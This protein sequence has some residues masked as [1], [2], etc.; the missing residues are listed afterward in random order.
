MFSKRHHRPLTAVAASLFVLVATSCS[1]EDPATTP[2]VGTDA[3][4][5]RSAVP[6][7][8][9]IDGTFD[10]GGHK[11][12]I[13]CAGTGTPTV[14][15]LHGWIVNEID[16]PHAN[17]VGIQTALQ[18]DYRV[19]L[20]D[21]R[22]V[23][24][25][26]TV[27]APQG[28]DNVMGD[29]R[30]LL[31]AAAVEPPYVLLGASFGGLLA[32]LYAN[33]HPDEVVGMVLLDSGFP[34]E[35]SLEHLFPPKDRFKTQGANDACCTLERINHYKVYKEASRYIGKEPAIPVTY[36]AARQEPWDEN[37]YG[38]PEYDKAILDLQADF[39]DRFAPGEL[40]W[41][42]APHFMEPEVPEEIAGAVRDVI[43]S[44]GY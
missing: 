15:Y 28:P 36:F 34:D 27:D 23:A 37:D 8:D 19:C 2:G 40:V 3:T 14:I 44:A 10:V 42:D 4:S 13:N 25:S 29:L 43:A 32:Y 7:D 21:R 33:T 38:I 31:A 12:Y 17:A 16:D 41:V 11:L 9:V 26:E 35:L 6:D 20:Y 30:N 5:A 22:N 39:V 24:H 18:D 1:S